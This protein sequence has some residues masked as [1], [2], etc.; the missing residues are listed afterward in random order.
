MA[1]LNKNHTVPN[2]IY[3]SA[4]APVTLQAKAEGDE[5][6][7]RRFEMEAYTGGMIQ[8]SILPYPAVVNLNGMKIN[9]K[10]LPVFR[11]HDV[12]KEVGHTETIEKTKEDLNLT[13]VVSG[14][15]IA[16]QE[17]VG[18]ADNGFPWEA[19]IGATIQEIR[20]HKKGVKFSR[21]GRDFEGPAYSADKTTLREISFTG[22]GADSDTSA[23]MIAQAST[24][25]TVE[26]IEMDKFDEWVKAQ[27]FDAETLT[28]PQ[29]VTLKAAFDA[30]TKPPKIEEP[31]P[32]PEP[33][34]VD[35][36]KAMRENL[37][38][39]RT[40][41]AKMEEL[42][43]DNPELAIKAI[44]EGWTEDKAEL[45]M[46]RASRQTYF[47]AVNTGAGL[48]LTAKAIEASA[49]MNSGKVS[50][51]VLTADY[52]EKTLDAAKNARI[53]GPISL[54]ASAADLDGIHLPA[55]HRGKDAFIRAAF[56]SH[57][58]SGILSSTQNKMIL[59]GFRYV[60]D[61]WRM[62][63]RIG[64]VSDF[65][66]APR[67]RLNGA[68]EFDEIPA[69]GPIK[70]GSMSEED[71]SIQ[72]KTYAKMG[73]IDRKDLYNDDK[74]AL[75]QRPWML[76]R[77]AGLKL[78]DVF[79]TLFCNPTSFYSTTDTT[80]DE[81]QIKANQIANVF[82]IAGIAAAEAVFDAQVDANG[83]L[84]GENADRVIV[85]PALSAAAKVIYVSTELN[86]TTTA[87]VGKG[88]ANVYAGKY[89]PVKARYLA[90]SDYGNSAIIWY[91]LADPKVHAGFEVAFLDGKQTPTI[92][93]T[94]LSFQY[95]GIQ[96]RGY[97]DFGVAQLDPRACVKST[98]AG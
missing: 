8:L 87:N 10:A 45:E 5:S 70:Y 62:C 52:E 66:S 41:I 18:S 76:G 38:A 29:K 23:R 65:K 94:D 33:E 83:K 60:D 30:Q 32:D 69:G 6:K 35:E 96:F 40:R 36:I 28:E 44:G 90:D 91:M 80:T 84:I 34:K 64:S 19:S 27:G 63:C 43:K 39:E 53:S 4:T 21:N 17:V 98:G 2:E 68:F 73:G 72:A 93:E 77:G 7:L 75:S 46:L 79:W 88:K 51:D 74:N 26:V 71:Y 54:L 92:E 16:A 61:A 50:D 48:E 42:C 67:Y 47:P 9:K 82:N 95:L 89:N 15:G 59:A 13:G 86:E 58:L 81:A 97:Y 3:I 49:V 11:D 1:R 56:S 37:T 24:G 78:N 85:P 12:S 31:E 55:W 22:I 20:F 57:S 25:K 14:T